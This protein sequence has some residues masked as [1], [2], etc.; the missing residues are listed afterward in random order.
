MGELRQHYVHTWGKQGREKLVAGSSISKTSKDGQQRNPGTAGRR[1]GEHSEMRE[2]NETRKQALSRG[3]L[4][5]ERRGSQLRAGRKGRGS[6]Q[7]ESENP[8]LSSRGWKY[9]DKGEK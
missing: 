2:T 9:S 1:K 6:D 7:T 8:G 4:S 5:Q 3:W